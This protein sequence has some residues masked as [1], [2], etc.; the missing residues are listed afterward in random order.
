MANLS[1]LVTPSSSVTA[2]KLSGG[3]SGDA[4]IYGARA[5]VNFDATRNAAGNS[6]IDNTNRFIRA[7]GNVTSVMRNGLGSYTVTFAQALPN[8]CCA[9][10]NA[11]NTSGSGV[12]NVNQ[13]TSA[14]PGTNT[15][16]VFVV[17]V[18]NVGQ[19]VNVVT[20]MFIG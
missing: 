18:S 13:W 10:G 2:D 4:P 9:V 16:D 15:A 3:Q 1:T 20:F 6:V 17:D 5:W 14:N 19:D 8:N 12:A 7:Q 11:H